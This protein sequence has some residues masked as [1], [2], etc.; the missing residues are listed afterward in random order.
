MGRAVDDELREAGITMVQAGILYFVKVT[1][2]PVTPAMLARWL[3]RES[4]TVWAILDRM[5]KQGLIKKIRGLQRKNIVRVTL[6]EKGE[7]ACARAT[8]MKVLYNILSCLSPEERDTLRGYV[9]RLREKAIGEYREA[10]R[11]H[12]P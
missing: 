1:E 10:P 5:E 4:H 11:W 6:T 2:E 7:E 3:V 9:D 12:F 8:E